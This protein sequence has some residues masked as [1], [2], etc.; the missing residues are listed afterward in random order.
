MKSQWVH[1]TN[2][3]PEVCG[4]QV[5][6]HWQPAY[7]EWNKSRPNHVVQPYVEARFHSK[8]VTLLAS[9]DSTAVTCVR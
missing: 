1:F 7:R 4:K 9:H 2:W 5:E 6:Q 3:P 8:G